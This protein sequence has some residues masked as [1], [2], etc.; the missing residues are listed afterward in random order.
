M[1]MCVDEAGE[2]KFQSDLSRTAGLQTQLHKDNHA[3]AAEA[4][5]TG[6]EGGGSSFDGAGREEYR[7]PGAT[8]G[9]A[10]RRLVGGIE[11]EEEAEGLIG[12][13]GGARGPP[14]D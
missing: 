4:S 8:P 14:V 9:L 7:A 10:G 5:T 6:I 3:G 2:S 12:S 11:E 13:G 1:M